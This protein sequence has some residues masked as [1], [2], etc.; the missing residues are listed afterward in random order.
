MSRHVQVVTKG[1]FLDRVK[2]TKTC[3]LWQGQPSTTGP[4]YGSIRNNGVKTLA[5]RMSFLL[6][7]GEITKGLCV[8]HKCD[9]PLCVRPSHLFLGTLG[10]NNNDRHRKG[11]S[12]WGERNGNAKLTSRD[13]TRLKRKAKRGVSYVFLGKEFGL[14]P[15]TVSA[16]VRGN[17]WRNHDFE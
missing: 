17:K 5:H 9:V 4:G 15:Y 12:A 3:W 13:V 14:H 8:L 1:L 2:R 7:K 16:I 11:R 6:F 10:E